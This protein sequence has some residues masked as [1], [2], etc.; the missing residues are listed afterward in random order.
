MAVGCSAQC[1]VVFSLCLTW[2]ELSLRYFLCFKFRPNFQRLHHFLFFAV[3][4]E[5][6]LLPVQFAAHKLN[7]AATDFYCTLCIWQKVKPL[8]H[9][10]PFTLPVSSFKVVKIRILN[11]LLCIQTTDSMFF[12]SCCI[13]WKHSPK[14]QPDMF[15]VFGNFGIL[16]IKFCRFESP[17][18]LNVFVGWD[19]SWRGSSAWPES[20]HRWSLI[21]IIRSTC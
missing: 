1:S 14:I 19:Q 7:R 12:T 6:T 5:K 18:V 11:S 16:K 21:A 13:I 20:V 17:E 10:L 15:D 9:R 3:L 2:S 8:I 4:N